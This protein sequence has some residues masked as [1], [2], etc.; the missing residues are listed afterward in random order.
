MNKTE[1]CA[2]CD[3]AR[4]A[5]A[6]VN[7]D[8]DYGG[9][10]KARVRTDLRWNGWYCP[11]FTFAEAMRVAADTHLLG[12]KHN[13]QGDSV[14]F[15]SY[16][17]SR[18]AFVMTGGGRS[19]DDEPYIVEPTSCCGRYDIGA[20]NWTWVVVDEPE[21]GDLPQYTFAHLTEV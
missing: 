9:P 15:A 14:E 4:S 6:W 5:E 20:M 12:A 13:D 10:Y 1:Q 11:A 3:P 18:N 17:A 7:I 16:D 19:V 2:Y 21:I 8:E